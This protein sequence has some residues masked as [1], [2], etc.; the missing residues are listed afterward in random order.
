MQSMSD[1]ITKVSLIR[2]QDEV[3]DSENSK[4]CL[5]PILYMYKWN[6]AWTQLFP[7]NDILGMS[8]SCNS[9]VGALCC[10]ILSLNPY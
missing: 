3:E 7:G 4:T 9:V 5:L 8:G 10:C 2:L 1:K 6:V